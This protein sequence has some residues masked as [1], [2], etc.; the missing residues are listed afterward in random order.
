MMLASHWRDWHPDS[1]LMMA[2]CLKV[3]QG[4]RVAGRLLEYLKA[5]VG[6]VYASPDTCPSSEDLLSQRN[7]NPSPWFASKRRE[8]W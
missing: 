2:K 6:W 3:L 4:F 7:P 1:S 5:G 8:L